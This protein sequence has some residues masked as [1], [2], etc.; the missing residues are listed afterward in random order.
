MIENVDRR[1]LAGFRCVDAMTG[2]SI[3][4][5]LA[6]TTAP[7]VITRNRSGVFGRAL[8]FTCHRADQHAE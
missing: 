4:A 8:R 1:V 6:V 3:L 5:P 7:L 2:R